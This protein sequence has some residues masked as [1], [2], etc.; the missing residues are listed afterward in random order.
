MRSGWEGTQMPDQQSLEGCAEEFG[1]L[2][3]DVSGGETGANSP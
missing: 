1:E 3:E 2:P